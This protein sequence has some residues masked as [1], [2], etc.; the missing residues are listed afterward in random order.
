[1]NRL[2][3]FDCDGTLVDSQANICLAMEE[4]FVGAGLQAPP[5]ERIRRVVGLSLVEAMRAMLPEA[6]PDRHAALAE[7]YKIVFQALRGRG[8]V[9]EPLYDGIADLLDTLEAGGWRLAI[10]TGKSDRGLA[11]C[12]DRHGL[13]RRFVSLQT[14]DRHPSKPHPSMVA[15]AL[16]EAEAAPE[17]S[18]M[19]G[20]TSYDMAM[21]KAAGVRAIGVAWGYHDEQELL[22]AG[23]DYVAAHPSEIAEL[24]RA[25]A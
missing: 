5:R 10:A 11:L 12:L 13:S 6:G 16:A 24:V 14:A 25:F 4:C 2:A 15:Q 18:M 7:D 23:A 3:I 19:I 9:E 17:R 1:V 20:D 21:A 8:L 22:A